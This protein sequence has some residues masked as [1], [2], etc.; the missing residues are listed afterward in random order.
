M[1]LPRKLALRL[2]VQ[3]VIGAAKMAAQ[4]GGHPAVLREQVTSP[5][6]TT[7]AGLHQLEAKGFRNALISAVEAAA[8]RSRELRIE[9]AK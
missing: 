3:T 8:E 2:A 1:G 5:G 9:S 7:I 6:G 4:T